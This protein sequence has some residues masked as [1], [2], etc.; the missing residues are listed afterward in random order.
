MPTP[1]QLEQAHS[2]ILRH[3]MQKGYAPFYTELAS[4]LGVPVEEGR[5]TVHALIEA[6]IPGFV[7]P[8]TDHITAMPPFSSLPT[9]NRI[10]IDG[11]PGWYAQ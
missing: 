11:K 3:F 8:N 4:H 2:F 7:F 5:H 6:G 10:S 1:S 9:H